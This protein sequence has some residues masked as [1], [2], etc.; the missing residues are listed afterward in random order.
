MGRFLTDTMKSSATVPCSQDKITLER[1]LSLYEKYEADLKNVKSKMRGIA[2]QKGRPWPERYVGGRVLRK[3]A[4]TVGIMLP[5]DPPMLMQFDDISAEI[6]YLMVRDT[7]PD[8]VVEISPCHGWSTCWI[9]SALRDNRAGML[10]SYDV[11]DIAVRNIAPELSSGRWTFHKGDVCSNLE[12]IPSSIDYLFIDSDHSAKFAEWY[13]E[14]VVPRVVEGGVVSVDDV[15]HQ[16]DPGK[17]DGEG[18]VVVDWLEANRH[19][20]FCASS[21]G[22]ASEQNAINAHKIG[23]GIQQP[24]RTAT[25]NPTIFFL[26]KS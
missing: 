5:W 24:V 15:F 6:T 22:F 3:L 25:K 9:L 11:V 13:L 23:R 17:F 1:I 4:R 14:H 2:R 7:K 16:R 19:P 20:F 10:H 8:V 18:R 21:E 12:S 26:A